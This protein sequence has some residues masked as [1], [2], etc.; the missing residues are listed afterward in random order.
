[1]KEKEQIKSGVILSYVYLL[2]SVVIGLVYSPIMLEQMGQSEYGLY[3]IAKS[4]MSYL[5]IMGLGLSSSLTRFSIKYITAGDKE[6]ES[7]IYGAFIKLYSVICAATIVI[8]TVTA[9]ILMPLYES[10]L[11]PAEISTLRTLVIILSFNLGIGFPLG[12]FKSITISYE[13][14]NYQKILS[15]VTELI[16]PVLTL[17]V[18]FCG[19]RSIGVV[20]V[21]SVVSLISGLIDMQYSLRKLK[22]RIKFGKIQRGLIR[23]IAGYTGFIFIGLVTDRISDATNSLVLGAVCG[24]VEVSIYGIVMHV[25]TYY[26]NFSASISNVLTPK[27]QA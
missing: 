16:N 18:L 8:G 3:T 26:N 12:V 1:M 21:I 6:S 25:F 2:L 22:I 24:T 7:L 14:F 20:V 4:V 5:S 11:S 13:R 9:F 17:A 19:F 27:V 23:E 15:I 10:K